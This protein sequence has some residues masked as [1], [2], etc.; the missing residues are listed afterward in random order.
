MAVSHQM[1]I[2]AQVL[3]KLQGTFVINKPIHVGLSGFL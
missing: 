3:L 2:N 1:K